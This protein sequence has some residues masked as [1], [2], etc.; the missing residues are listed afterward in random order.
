VVVP[1]EEEKERGEKG[2]DEGE[3]RREKPFSP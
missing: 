2:E 1:D 3:K